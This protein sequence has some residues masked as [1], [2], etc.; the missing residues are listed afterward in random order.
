[1]LIYNHRYTDTFIEYCNNDKM[2]KTIN[3]K[4]HNIYVWEHNGSR[5]TTY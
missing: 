2:V 1:M 5:N 4:I 3:D